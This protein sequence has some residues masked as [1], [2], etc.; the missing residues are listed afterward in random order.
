MRYAMLRFALLLISLL[1]LPAQAQEVRIWSPFQVDPNR[2]AATTAEEEA[3]ARAQI[4]LRRT[5]IGL[6]TVAQNALVDTA[7][8]GHSKY[9]ATN[10]LTGHFQSSSQFPSGFTGTDPGA[11]LTA[12]GYPYKAYSEVIAFGPSSGVTAIENLIQAIYH[13]FGIFSTNVDEVGVGY[14]DAHPT[15]KYVVTADFAAKSSTVAQPSSWVGVYPIDGQTNVPVDFFTDEESPDPVAEANRV[16]YAASLHIDGNR[17]LTTTSF[18]LTNAAGTVLNT[19]LLS[20][21]SDS[22]TPKSVAS[23][24]PLSVLDYGATYTAKFV[25]SANGTALSKTWSFTT[26][27]LTNIAF[28]PAS[29][30]AGVGVTFVLQLSGG[31]GRFTNVGW[32]SSSVLSVAFLSSTSLQVTT[33]A[34]GSATITVTDTEGRQGSTTV[35][36]QPGAGDPTA[37]T[38]PTLSLSTTAINFGSVSVGQNSS[39]QT[40][41]LSNTGSSSISFSNIAVTGDFTLS[42]GCSSTLAAGSTCSVALTFKPTV[43]GSRTG[44]LSISSNAGSSP[45]SVALS[46][47]GSDSTVFG[48][49]ATASG[50]N[51]SLT[52]AGKLVVATADVGQTGSIFLGALVGNLWFLHNGSTWVPLG[53][54][55]PAFQTGTLAA[56]TEIPIL[57]AMNVSSLCQTGVYIGYGKDAQDMINKSQ[58]KLVYTLCQ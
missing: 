11:R 47:T 23:I 25:G 29:P 28:S 15:Y 35:T 50:S 6:P 27:P 40:V 10:N 49:S 5:Q 55:I 17:T 41:T 46:G 51:S 2:F 57:S 8:L 32:T 16:G 44:S 21:S 24:I 31:S 7:A 4:N 33:K 18:T 14:S 22:N 37:T 20:N 54:N 45:H 12:A 34:A 38:A 36:V 19:K 13:R 52:L 43:S 56:S 42:N 3:N 58:F 30:T 26:M 39:A 48:A 1:S 53:A 9:L